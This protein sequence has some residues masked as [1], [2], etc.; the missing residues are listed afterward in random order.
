M[1]QMKKGESICFLDNRY[2]L[3]TDADDRG[4]E[5]IVVWGACVEL[6]T[7]EN[8]GSRFFL[9]YAEAN[10]EKKNQYAVSLLKRENGFRMEHPYIERIIA[11]GSFTAET[12]EKLYGVLGEYIEGD[13]LKEYWK[14]HR[15]MEEK[16]KFRYMMQLLNAMNYYTCHV[17]GDS[18]V[19]RD[20]KPDNI[21]V[22]TKADKAVMIDFD[23]SHIPGLGLTE[24]GFDDS[25]IKAL[26]GTR[27]FSDPRCFVQYERRELLELAQ[28]IRGDI[29]AMGRTFWFLLT[30]SEYYT[31]EEKEAY[32]ENDGIDDGLAYGIMREKI[33]DQYR[34]EKYAEL[35]R[36]LEK[37]TARPE[38]RYQKAAEIIKDMKKYM[39]RYLG[40]ETEYEDIISDPLLLKSRE[41][42]QLGE[43]VSVGYKVSAE[44]SRVI[45]ALCPYQ[46]H[47]ILDGNRRPIMAVYNLG[48]EIWFIPYDRELKKE[49]ED[50]SWK[51]RPDDVFHLREIS[52]DFM[53]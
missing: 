14:K 8:A 16:K 23:S 9:K 29:Y 48:G 51:I 38:D 13:N 52:I 27:G 22:C 35:I 6:C 11:G 44:T 30:G 10:A 24:R 33:P 17:K 50:G 49:K 39:V 20:V 18:F 7:G 31:L 41:D 5:S 42:R 19:H 53:M 45:I 26:R 3:L 47:D 1:R 34:Q 32:V 12:G 46:M 28:D 37:M 25:N 21:M 36:I 15:H 43:R 40:G 2:V 4:R